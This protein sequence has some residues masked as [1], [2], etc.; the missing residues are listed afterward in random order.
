MTEH[1]LR[2]GLCLVATACAALTISTGPVMATGTTSGQPSAGA[3][4]A[5]TRAL[6]KLE[7]RA[8]AVQAR[9]TQAEVAHADA[10]EALTLQTDNVVRL[11]DQV[12]QAERVAHRLYQEAT[13]EAPDGALDSLAGWL[14][15]SEADDA[16]DRAADAAANVAHLQHLLELANRALEQ[17]Q[18]NLAAAE[19]EQRAAEAQAAELSGAM[20]ARAAALTATRQA[21]LPQTYRASDRAQDRLNRRALADWHGYLDSVAD[22]GIVP[23]R[24]EMLL[25]PA[26]LPGRLDQVHDRSGRPMKGSAQVYS[27][28]AAPL[29]IVSGETVRAV[30][31]AF[32]QLGLRDEPAADRVAF[33]C[34]GLLAAGWEPTAVRVPA[35]LEDQWHDTYAVPVRQAQVGDTVYLEDRDGVAGAGIYLGDKQAIVFDAAAGEVAV[36]NVRARDILGVRRLTV[37]A[38]ERRTTPPMPAALTSAC[39]PD[40]TD[41]KLPDVPGSAP[42][43]SSAWTMPLAEGTYVM[44]AAFGVDG[45]MW[46]S[47]EH[48]GQDF[49]AA[50]GTPVYATRGGVVTVEDVDWSGRLV[51][52]DHGGG[53]ESWYAHMSAVHVA[54]GD[55]VRAG[56]LVGAVGSEGNSTGP[57]LH[58]EIRMNGSSLDPML[59]LSGEAAARSLALSAG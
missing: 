41:E 40:T 13:E 57:H 21:E 6:T 1:L 19:H 47:G 5:E 11:T 53:V 58:F 59:L 10:V 28:G 23:P 15:G 56:E 26:Q 3:I 12:E 54:T 38:D 46:S 4:K 36:R 37:A 39:V 18:R 42:E 33:A 31:A 7:R 48:T 34:T 51:R 29:R 20:T 45:S 35:N 44:S 2:R 52:I 43:S 17:G 16:V 24:T 55:T 25:R 8:I 27:T 22:A 9:V 50:E 30:S 14:F 32:G 49:A